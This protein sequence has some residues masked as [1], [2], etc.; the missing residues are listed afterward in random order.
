MC[1]WFLSSYLIILTLAT[2][3]NQY[4]NQNLASCIC[5]TSSSPDHHHRPDLASL[6]RV[7][8]P[9]NLIQDILTQINRR[10]TNLILIPLAHPLPNLITFPRRRRHHI[11]NLARIR[12]SHNIYPITVSLEIR[13]QGVDLSLPSID[14][15]EHGEDFDVD[16]EIRSVHRSIFVEYARPGGAACG[17]P[18]GT[19]A[20][21]DAGDEGLL[22]VGEERFGDFG[23]QRAVSRKYLDEGS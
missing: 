20:C 16:T 7:R 9:W 10:N 13:R 22:A 15:R 4:Y 19:K 6:K 8:C 18:D 12:H 2:P 3:S 5:R 17:I 14:S 11:P 1:V 23:T 21:S